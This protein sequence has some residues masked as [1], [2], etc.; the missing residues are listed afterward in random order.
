VTA[1]ASGLDPHISLAAARWQVA[2]VARARRV[3]PRRIGRWS[4][5]TSKD[6]SSASSAKRG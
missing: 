1:S 6:G 3:D 4:H 2:R 5:G